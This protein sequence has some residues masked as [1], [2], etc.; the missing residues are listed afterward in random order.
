M[1]VTDHTPGPC[2]AKSLTPSKEKVKNSHCRLIFPPVK[3]HCPGFPQNPRF[4]N[5]YHRYRLIDKHETFQ[6]IP[7][8][9]SESQPLRRTQNAAF[10]ISDHDFRFFGRSVSDN[11]IPPLT[12]KKT[13]RLR[14]IT[15]PREINLHFQYRT[16]FSQ[17][18]PHHCH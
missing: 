10:P 9:R 6:D 1:Q 14:E 7:R 3:L 2:V 8:I 17:F 5:L 4:P 16:N 12:I 18:P 13:T 15:M 11:F